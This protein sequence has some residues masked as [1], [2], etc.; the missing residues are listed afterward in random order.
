MLASYGYDDL[1]RRTSLTRGN[2]T[3]TRYGYTSLSQLQTLT[4]DVA[5]GA[6][7]VHSTYSYNPAGQINSRTTSNDAYVWTGLVNVDRSYGV[8]GLNQLTSSGNVSLGY[9][10]RGNLT[11]SGTSG[12][13]YTAENRLAWINEATETKALADD[14]VG[15]LLQL[16]DPAGPTATRFDNMGDRLITGFDASGNTARPLTPLG[17][18][19]PVRPAPAHRGIAGRSPPK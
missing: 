19:F 14:P 12:Y 7:D 4:H 3:V 18:R 11:S 6:H 8:N 5:G 10:A 13:A 1:G 15:R 2:G 17:G 16:Y 9:D